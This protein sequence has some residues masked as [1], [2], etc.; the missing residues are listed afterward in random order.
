MKKGEYIEIRKKQKIRSNISGITCTIAFH[1]AFAG[2]L[3]GAGIHYLDPPPPEQEQILIDF[4]ESDIPKPEQVWNGTMP[5]AVNPDP[6]QDINLV[7]R[8]EAQTEG[9]TAN[10]A[11]EAVVD[12]FGDV[13]VKQAPVKKEINRR[14]LFQ[15]ADNK[16]EKDTLAPQVA[17][18]VTDALKA[19]HAQGNTKTGITSGEPN[20]KLAGR[21]VNG[22]LA[23]PSYSVQKSGTVVVDIWVDN[24]GKVQI[25]IPGV[26]GTTV[27][28]KAL[29]NAARKAA[30]ET[31]FNMSAT[32]P[33]QQKG[34]I[35]YVFKLD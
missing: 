30:L 22:T 17:D 9:T 2:V 31:S 26:E 3:M 8:A 15:A 24:Y 5:Q 1:A 16:T 6:T 29:W 35:T 7:Q 14:A 32:A 27:T 21:S 18:K 19:G 4:S 20:A 10:E 25:A 13:E 34:T 28:D 33:T 11:P 12:D 23:R